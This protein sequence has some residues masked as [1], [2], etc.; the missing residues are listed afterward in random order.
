MILTPFVE[1]KELVEFCEKCAT[2]L[3]KVGMCACM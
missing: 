3:D 1:D 2:D